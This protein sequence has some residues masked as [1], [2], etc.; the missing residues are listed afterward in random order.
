MTEIIDGQTGELIPYEAPAP[1]T[2]FGS[3]NPAEVLEA[4]AIVAKALADV[5]EKQN[6]SA[7]IGSS[8]HI[9]VE[10]W[11]LLGSMT[12]VF[13]VVEWTRPLENGWEARV[14]ARTKNG[15]LVGAA[16]AMCTKAENT[17]KNRDDYAIRAMAQTRA[18][19]RALR[20][21]LG[22]IVELAGYNA[23][24][25]EEMPREP[26]PSASGTDT[27]LAT[28]PQRRRL[29]ALIGEL[30]KK[31]GVDPPEGESWEEYVR[32]YMERTWALD[33][34]TKL[35]RGQMQFLY[36]HLEGPTPF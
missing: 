21:P 27:K 2:L 10:G 14:E 15:E 12:G 28:E 13:P 32:A 17:W 18:T 20:G 1:V 26:N 30:D 19:S 23:T 35:T 33:S 16:E 5:I 6:L 4:A 24:A 8:T 36:E 3:N 9:L 7:K 25:A 29:F 22:F 11:T 34:T 31:E